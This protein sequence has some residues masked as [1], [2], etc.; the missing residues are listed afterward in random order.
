MGIKKEVLKIND[1]TCTSCEA[2]IEKAIKN[3]EGVLYVK[4][5][6]SKSTAEVL[7]HEELCTPIQMKEAIEKDGYSVSLGST[8]GINKIIGVAFIGV[9]IVALGKLSSNYDMSAMLSN[10]TY[11]MLFVV[12]LISSI[13]C[14][15]M[16][17]GI[18]LSQSISKEGAQ[19]KLESIKPALLYNGG[20][21]ISYTI[22]G[23]VI[24]ALGSVLSLSLKMK[25]TMQLF[26]GLFMII[27][28]LNMFGLSWFRKIHIKLPWSTCSVK[29]KSKMPFV[30]GLLNGL[31]PCGPLQTMQLFAL[32]TGSS[33]KGAASMF[34]FAIGTVPLML[35]FGTISG[36]LSKGYTKK[37]L[38]FSGVLVILLGF[39]MGN[40]GLALSGINLSSFSSIVNI[41][42]DK[43]KSETKP[44]TN[45]G[46][47]LVQNNVQVIRMSALSEGYKPNALVVQKGIPV[48]WIVNGEQ[49][50]SCN[51]TIVVPS[52]KIQKDLMKGENTIEFT[53]ISAGDINF[54][55]SMGMIRGVIKVVD[56]LKNADTA[57]VLNNVPPANGPSYN[58]NNG[59]KTQA[60]SIYGDD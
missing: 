39:V 51:S 53:P 12:G 16:C 24:G 6:Y 43:T 31:M 33:L 47:S 27:M 58:S 38:K 46:T 4:A 56:E 48:K 44:K 52:L 59:S 49:L 10:A 45:V 54:S 11:L 26:A 30:V 18:M 25:A 3:L 22:L 42:P 15:G 17:G 29:Q 40:R 28:G 2:R 5:S 14:V 37:L 21:V 8:G 57:Q 60:S 19:S 36:L 9:A 34:F 50:T 13:H 20:R 41:F 35:T 7:F 23:G 55:C 32:G 1:M